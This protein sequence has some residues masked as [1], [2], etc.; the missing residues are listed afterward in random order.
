[1]DGPRI[2]ATTTVL[3]DAQAANHG[4]YLATS[5][6]LIT[7]K[8]VDIDHFGPS[9]STFNPECWLDFLRQQPKRKYHSWCLSRR[10]W[11]DS[12]NRQAP[13]HHTT[14]AAIYFRLRYAVLRRISSVEVEQSDSSSALQHI[15]LLKAEELSTSTTCFLQYSTMLISNTT[16]ITASNLGPFLYIH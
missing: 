10:P 12:Q 1:L 16:S 3:I 5:L 2:P 15:F 14:T 4:T 6:K 11:K 7:N 8:D 13:T 9:A